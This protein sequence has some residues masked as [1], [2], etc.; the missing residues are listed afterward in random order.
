MAR[1]TPSPGRRP[2]WFRG[3]SRWAAGFSSDAVRGG[4]FFDVETDL[5]FELLGWRGQER[6]EFL[7]DVAE[8]GVVDEQGFVNFRQPPKNGG[9]GGMLFAH[10]DECADD[11]NT[12]RHGARSVEDGAGHERAVFG[13]CES[14][15]L[16][17]VAAPRL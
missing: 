1:I 2:A 8:S 12:H 9:I 3:R 17:V 14:G 4:V 5:G 11:V 6:T 13:K 15:I 16:A 7:V 10:F